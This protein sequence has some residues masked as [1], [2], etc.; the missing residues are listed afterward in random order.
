V[1]SFEIAGAT[2]MELRQGGALYLINGFTFRE[3][4]EMFTRK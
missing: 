1:S 2:R 4:K 3:I